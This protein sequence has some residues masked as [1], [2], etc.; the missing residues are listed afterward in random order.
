MFNSFIKGSII[1]TM[2]FLVA[3]TA[4]F[5]YAYEE[6]ALDADKLINYK[7]ETSSVILD[8]NG[9]K[10]AYVYKRQHR[11]YATYDEIPGILVEGLV[12]MEDTKF[13]EHNGVN[14]DAIIRALIKDIKAG[15]FVEGG[16]TLTQQLI[17]NKI[18][19]NEKKLARKIKEAILAIKIENVLSKEDIIERY[20][21]EISYGNNYFGVKTAANGYFHKELSELTLKEAAILV[22]LPNAPSYY[23]PLRHYK[24]ALNRA[25]NVLYRMKSIGWLTESTY[26]AAV[27]ESPKVYKTPLA[28]NIAPYIVDE[29][30]RRFKGKLGDIRTG[31]YKI[32]TTIDM[33]Q[34][35][36]ARDAVDFAYKKA[37]KK[38]KESA[39]KSTLNAAFV[40]VESSTGDVLAM[41]GGVNYKKSAFNR[42]T[43]SERQPGS[44]FKPFIYQTALDMGYNP[45]SPL[46][47][48][49]RTFHY[50]SN[51]K[52]K[53]WAPRNYE[54]D[55][56]GFMPLREALVHSRNLATINLVS[57]LG[58]ST[59]RK[60]LAFLDVPHIPRDMSIALGNLGLSPMKMAQIF[61]VFANK[62][63]MIE[64]RLVNK[65]ISREG[66]VIYATRP[67][68]IEGFSTPEQTY[69]MTDILKDVVKRGTGKNAQVKGLEL[70]GKTGTTNKNVDAWF[71]GYSPTIEAIVWFGRDNNKPIGRSATGG[72]IA[73]PAF[74]YYFRELLKEYPETKRTFDIPQNVFMGTYEGKQELYTDISPFPDSKK[75]KDDPFINIT[76]DDDNDNDGYVIDGFEDISPEEDMG[77]AETIN[78]D[79][80]PFIDLD[81]DD[82]LHPR[83]NVPD[84]PVSNDSGTMF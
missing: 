43:Q 82:P 77:M 62:G 10:L 83:R 12:A 24:R 40:A 28:Q 49:A 63:H 4:A 70:A 78:I 55:F 56:K 41:V 84:V 23:N 46:T 50:Y 37:L 7:P 20:L 36:I 51:G 25:N 18:L 48:L 38:Y 3:L 57:D 64:P 11:L 13:F 19:S 21:N 32:Y 68:E 60:R 22:A 76:S 31:G 59:I 29:V 66:A 33:K 9:N 47:D 79:E 75:M 54:R 34:Q 26:L 27:K 1:L 16:S 71:C 80:D 58:V 35:K 6:I 52:P 5:I 42:A 30:L 44:A 67:K 72:A 61:S 39:D 17:K 69:M 14:P 73:A 15:K 65:V 45:A 8:R 2:L 81:N 74:A 53:V